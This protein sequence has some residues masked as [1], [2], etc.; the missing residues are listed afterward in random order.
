LSR[1]RVLLVDDSEAVL[2]FETAALGGRFAVQTALHGAEALAKLEIEVPDLLVLDL[3][4]PVMNGEQVLARV[5][6]EPRLRGLPVLIVSS[7]SERARAC[8]ARGARAFLHKPIR[9]DDLLATATRLVDEERAAQQRAFLA[10]LPMRVG[11]MELAVTLDA[12]DLV[13]P[14]VTTSPLAFGPPYL[15]EVF[16]LYGEPVLALDL[17]ARLGVPHAAP[18]VDRK[19]VV[20]RQLAIKL[21]LCVD[22]VR[23][24]EEIAPENVVAKQQVG[25][26]SHGELRD[27]LVAVVRTARGPIPLVESSSFVEPGLLDPLVAW[28]AAHHETSVDALEARWE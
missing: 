24:P 9:A 10:C 11:A 13:V 16:D 19:L 17:A 15:R 23:D 12:V 2:A 25:G 6:S 1:S 7:E 22:D 3:S 20:L 14:Q 8:L 4:M 21:A 18:R 28:L 27:T 26:A 5:T